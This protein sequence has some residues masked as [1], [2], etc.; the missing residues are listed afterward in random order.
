MGGVTSLC[1]AHSCVCVCALEQSNAGRIVP[2]TRQRWHNTGML[3]IYRGELFKELARLTHTNSPPPMCNFFS[4]S[5]F[6]HISMPHN[7]PFVLYLSGN[8]PLFTQPDTW[9]SLGW[10]R[11]VFLHFPLTGRKI[12]VRKIPPRKSLI[13]RN[14][15]RRFLALHIHKNNP[16]HPCGGYIGSEKSV[17]KREEKKE[18]LS[19]RCDIPRIFSFTPKYT[20]KS[21]RLFE[22]EKS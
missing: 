7:F 3:S 21:K 20:Q 13:T 19:R 4:F 5:S 10:W 9:E 8:Q 18:K 1:R 15:T 11:I 12:F 16:P 14:V 17:K 22:M 6:S 2:K